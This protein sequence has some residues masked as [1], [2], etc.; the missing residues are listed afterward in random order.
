VVKR[1]ERRGGRGRGES[2]PSRVRGLLVELKWRRLMVVQQRRWWWCGS[3]AAA[4]A[5]ARR[6]RTKRGGQRLRSR[7]RAARAG[8]C[9]VEAA[10]A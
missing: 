3:L 10:A 1:R 5:A 4:A 9:C 2:S 8:H 6:S 7:T